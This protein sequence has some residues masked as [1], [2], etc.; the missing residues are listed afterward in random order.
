M[1]EPTTG[2][3]V[4]SVIRG[5]AHEAAPRLLAEAFD[6]AYDEARSIIRKLMVDALLREA[7]GPTDR[8]DAPADLPSPHRD[9]SRAETGPVDAGVYVYGFALGSSEGDACGTG[10][11]GLPTSAIKYQQVAAIVSDVHGAPL[12]WGGGEG[13]T[14][15]LAAVGARAQEHERVLQAILEAGPVVPMRFGTVYPSGAAVLETLRAHY[16]AIHAALVALDG[17]AEWGLTVTCHR[18]R[19]D[20]AV[21]QTTPRLP[22]EAAG[23]AYLNRREADKAAAERSA[24]H[25]REVA[26]ALHRAI[27]AVAAGTV[28]HPARRPSGGRER[29]VDVLLRASYLVDQADRDHFQEAIASVLE[30]AADPGLAGELTGP[31]PP[32]NFSRLQLD[33]APA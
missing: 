10:V 16:P 9:H 19:A 23:R 27:E 17:K 7:G 13:G 15:D 2:E 12:A 4:H 31:W 6:D 20:L 24:R 28:V 1:T 33:G 22:G 30:R 5:L 26:T 14:P 21:T 18:S 25:R 32:Y 11:H 3:S 29:D 8:G